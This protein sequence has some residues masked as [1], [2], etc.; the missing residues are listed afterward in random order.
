MDKIDDWI[1]LGEMDQLFVYFTYELPWSILK[2]NL[3]FWNIN[4]NGEYS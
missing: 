1:I 2:G 4:D 3:F